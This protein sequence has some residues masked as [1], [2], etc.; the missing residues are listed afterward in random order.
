MNLMA[1]DL[2]K[3][4]GWAFA[5][6]WSTPSFGVKEFP[7]NRGDY[8]VPLGTV[9]RLFR[10]WLLDMI[11]LHRPDKLLYEAP[12]ISG[13]GDLYK[14]MVLLGMAAMTECVCDEAGIDCYQESSA[15][16]RK[17]FI[18]VGRGKS[19]DLKDAVGYRCRQLGW[20]VSDHNAADALAALAYARDCFLPRAAQQLLGGV[21]G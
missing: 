8:E 19:A 20:Q 18:G 2:S 1:L 13:G 11:A 12:I 17:H 7:R 21:R 3:S 5:R 15:T 14:H 6:G 9:L 10:E 4:T 16:I